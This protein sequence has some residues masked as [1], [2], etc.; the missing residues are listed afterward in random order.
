MKVNDAHTAFINCG[1]ILN[2]YTSPSRYTF[3]INST[4]HCGPYREDLYRISPNG[5]LVTFEFP[6]AVG[7]VLGIIC[8]LISIILVISMISTYL[9]NKWKKSAPVL[10]D[11]QEIK[12]NDID[13]N[14]TL[15]TPV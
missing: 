1:P 3:V 9:I 13:Q 15:T 8:G 6:I 7:S 14:F 11:N 10:E 12:L 4:Y 5:P 2:C